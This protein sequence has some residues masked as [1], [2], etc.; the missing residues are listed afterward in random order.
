MRPFILA[1]FMVSILS[2]QDPRIVSPI[3]FTG[4]VA[5]GRDFEREFQ[6][7]LLFRLRAEKDPASPGWEIQVSPKSGPQTTEYSWVVTP[8]YHF[9]NPR[10]LFVSYGFSAREIVAMNPRAFSFVRN[11]FDFDRARTDVDFMLGYT[12]PPPG[13][14]ALSVLD[15]A[16]ADLA[17]IPYCSGIVRILDHRLAANDGPVKEVIDW[18]K[19]EVELCRK[20]R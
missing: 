20:D 13:E 3:K 6:P 5:R 18:I 17:K 8:P 19:F 14:S 1:A 11:P 9:F 10:Y 16:S 7:G 2:A 4:E 15:R 12:P